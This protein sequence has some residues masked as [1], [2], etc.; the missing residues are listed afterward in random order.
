MLL[1]AASSPCCLSLEKPTKDRT[2]M[3]FITGAVFFPFSVTFLG[4]RSNSYRIHL[5]VV[6]GSSRE[7]MLA[8]NDTF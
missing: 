5:A 2:G 1:P 7:G 3:G 4:S 8:S 6:R